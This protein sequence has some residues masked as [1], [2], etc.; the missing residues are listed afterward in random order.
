MNVRGWFP[1]LQ[2]DREAFVV[3]VLVNLCHNVANA[4]LHPIVHSIF[5]QRDL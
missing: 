2:G 5:G 1:V 3:I 4:E